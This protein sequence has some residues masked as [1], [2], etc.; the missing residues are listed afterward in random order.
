MV[1]VF[2]GELGFFGFIS[3]FVFFFIKERI[4][5]VSYFMDICFGVVYDIWWIVDVSI[6]WM[7]YILVFF[8]CLGY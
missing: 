7:V 6:I 5:K 1:D 4:V 8:S 2:W 3:V